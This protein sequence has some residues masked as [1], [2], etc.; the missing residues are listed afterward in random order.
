MNGD[1]PD[2][3]PA[4][5]ENTERLIR[6]IRE[7]FTSSEENQKKITKHT[8]GDWLIREDE[9]QEKVFIILEGEVALYKTTDNGERLQVDSL[10][11]GDMMGLLSYF[12]RNRNFVGGRC[13]TEVT[14]VRLTW[15]EFDHYNYTDPIGGALLMLIRDNMAQ[16]YRRMVGV[17]L[18]L[19]TLNTTLAKE[20]NELRD[21]IIELEQTRNRLV[22]Q[23]RL[24]ILGQLI[25]GLAH[26]IN[27]PAAAMLRSTDYL[28]ESLA[29]L[30]GILKE[31]DLTVVRETGPAFWED[32][33]HA[34]NH[35]LREDI[36]KKRAEWEKIFPGLPRSLYRRLSFLPETT[37]NR[38]KE[39][40]L[41]QKT[42]RK[43]KSMGT[44]ANFLEEVILP[45]ETAHHVRT[46]SIAGDRIRKLI[47]GLKNYSRPGQVKNS[48][49]DLRQGIEDTLMILS[50]RL[51]EVF[52]HLDSPEKLEAPG[53]AG[54]LNQVWTNIMV[55]ACDSME[56]HGRLDIK[57]IKTEEDQ[58]KITFE[59]TGP[60]LPQGI[61]DKL[62]KPNFTTKN[63]SRSFGL[64]LGLSIAKDIIEKHNG[65]IYAENRESGGA[66][67]V[68]FLPLR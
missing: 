7:A 14:A 39:N 22:N 67:F 33:L 9:R 24:A 58:V 31:K 65:Q 21:T 17:Q 27:N 57:L 26:E 10:S 28:R 55:N 35:P 1:G 43:A 52:V 37:S 8:S 51:K 32:G 66:R 40:T 16:R 64:G 38:L 47:A 44:K 56:D 46:V 25:A 2:K 6:E 48:S 59:D 60:G 42:F 34:G 50:N 13:Q 68:I 4:S 49:V 53:N 15:E 3:I 30:F 23:E 45:F 18:K 11:S 54:E 5:I 12:A 19:A 41:I 62:F 20:R 63:Q 61:L 36:E 29:H